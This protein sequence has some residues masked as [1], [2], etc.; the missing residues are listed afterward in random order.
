M[1]APTR[2][3][4][5]IDE[6]TIDT[7][8]IGYRQTDQPNCY[9]M[10]EIEYKGNGIGWVWCDPKH[11]VKNLSFLEKY[12]TFQEQEEWYKKH[13]NINDSHTYL[14]L[15]GLFHDMYNT[16]TA[17]H[18]MWNAWVSNNFYETNAYLKDED[19]I[20]IGVAAAPYEWNIGGNCC[21]LVIEDRVTGSNYWCHAAQ[22]W[23]D[24]MREQMRDI[25]KENKL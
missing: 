24:E 12:T 5:P 17:T 18:E 4:I 8:Y 6:A 20:L 10:C 15:C 1:K 14:N 16:G 22:D 3:W 2:I 9:H 21:A 19:M 25:Y 11:E 23:V 7:T 13:F